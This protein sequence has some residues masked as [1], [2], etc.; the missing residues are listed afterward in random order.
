M[1]ISLDAGDW[2]PQSL[3]PTEHE[4]LTLSNELGSAMLGFNRADWEIGVDDE[5]W[6]TCY[7]PKAFIDALVADIRNSHIY[8]MRLGLKLQGLYTTDPFSY[9]GDLF[10]RPD[11]KDNTIAIP[12]MATGFVR[13]INFTST[14]R[15]LR[16][17]EPAEPVEPEYEDTPPNPDPMAVAI[18]SLGAQVEQMRNTFKWIASFIVL[19]LIFA[20]GK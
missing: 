4:L 14:P 19:A 17:P 16:K 6:I 1:T 15:D 10:I 20:A 3:E 12:D 5:W 9:R 18:A 13:S 8:S 7:L 11:R 2:K